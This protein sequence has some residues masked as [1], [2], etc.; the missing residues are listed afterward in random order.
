M[1]AVH[2]EAAERIVQR[3]TDAGLPLNFPSHQFGVVTREKLLLLIKTI[4]SPYDMKRPV[5]KW[6]LERRKGKDDDFTK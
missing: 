6:M 5:P 2:E 3:L 1:S 4:L